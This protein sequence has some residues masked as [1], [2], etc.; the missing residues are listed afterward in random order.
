MSEPGSRK[1]LLAVSSSGGHWQQL[2]LLGEAFADFDVVYASTV[3]ESRP[4]D[5]GTSLR[6]R[7]VN[8]TQPWLALPALWEAL[9]LVRGLRPA[10]IVSTGAGPGLLVLLAGR[11]LGVPT[12][13]V[14]SVANAERLSMSGWLARRF[15]QL[16]CS[17]WEH[18]A[19]EGRT[20]FLGRML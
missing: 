15:V 16:H 7:E 5:G 13:W 12:V 17:Q 1:R 3:A 8:R 10:V 19:D 2:L 14:D 6:L 18:L 4:A 20:K 9:L 11:L